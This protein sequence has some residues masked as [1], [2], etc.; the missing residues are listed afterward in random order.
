M[1]LN[2]EYVV[3]LLFEQKGRA[4]SRQGNGFFDKPISLERIKQADMS[5]Q[6]TRLVGDDWFL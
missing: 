2:L 3:C 6:D 5:V 1:V 4:T